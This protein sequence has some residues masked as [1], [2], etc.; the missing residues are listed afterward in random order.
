LILF[1]VFSIILI[2]KK[3]KY[4]QMSKN[5][6]KDRWKVLQNAEKSSICVDLNN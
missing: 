1:I 5:V 3:N 6:E 4:K 2:Y